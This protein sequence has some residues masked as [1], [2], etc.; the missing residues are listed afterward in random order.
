MKELEAKFLLQ[1]GTRRTKVLRRA[2]QELSWAGFLAHPLGVMRI[3]DT[4]YDTCDTV[5]QNVG[6]SLRCRQERSA[7]QLTLKQLATPKAGMFSRRERQQT[8]GWS[9]AANI[10]ADWMRWNAARLSTCCAPR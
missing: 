4:Y 3:Q 7:S 5:L 2:L 9:S 1:Q 6:W 10:T 8:L